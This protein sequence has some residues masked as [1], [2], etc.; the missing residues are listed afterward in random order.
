[1]GML[2]G[3]TAIISGAGT[4]LGRAAAVVFAGE[5]AVVALVGRRRTK[6]EETAA[7]IAQHGMGSA[8][9][10]PADVSD[11]RQVGLAVETVMAATGR[12]DILVNNAAVFEPGRVAEMT[13]AEWTLQLAVN[14]TGPFLL[15]KA[16]IPAMRKARYGRIVNITSGLAGNG[17]GGY[18]AYS[19]SKAGLESLT[20]TVADEESGS[21]II[22]N[23][24]NPGT[25]RSE[26]HATGKDPRLVAP[27]LLKLAAVPPGGPSGTL[28]S[29]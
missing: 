28:V 2:S 14:L 19:A 1:M 15:T 9:V 25:I 12:I 8:L 3:R 6:L 10:V 4:G 29:H 22:A 21:G 17:A 23:L 13:E 20:R 5:G 16:V 7:M 11:E 18:A 26:M 24:F 27:D